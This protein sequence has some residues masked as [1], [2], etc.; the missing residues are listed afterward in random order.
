MSFLIKATSD[1]DIDAII[2]VINDS[3]E[4]FSFKFQLDRT[5]F[6][7]CARFWNFS[8]E[9]SYL[10]YVDSHPVTVVINSVDCVAREGCTFYWG[11]LP[12][13]RG[14]GLGSALYRAYLDQVTDGGFV[15]NYLDISPDS[16]YSLYRRLGYETTHE[17]VQMKGLVP[18]PLGSLRDADATNVMRIQPE[19]FFND[20]TQSGRRSWTRRAGTLRMAS[21]FLQFVK[22]SNTYATYLFHP[23]GSTVIDFRWD[24]QTES[25]V[26]ALL[27]HIVADAEE[28][29]VYFFDVP[30]ASPLRDLLA[31]FGFTIT[32]RSQS[33]LLDLDR[34]RR[35]AKT[36]R[37]NK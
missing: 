20:S 32:D 11:V 15:R 33:L 8:F 24:D 2:R 28:R 27:N 14:K 3:S 5:S 36:F 9:H 26:L 22:C 34:W 6:A 21:P 30:V 35:S 7:A 4:G 18:N 19:E 10:G 17:K 12:E 13:F 23:R 29:V 31:K 1:N 37:Q 25:P 16:P